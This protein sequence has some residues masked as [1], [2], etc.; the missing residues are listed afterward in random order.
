MNGARRRR[1]K[2]TIEKIL[3]ANLFVFACSGCNFECAINV[4]SS[5]AHF[6]VYFIY[7]QMKLI[8]SAMNDIQI[9]LTEDIFRKWF[10]RFK[11][12]KQF[13]CVPQNSLVLSIE[14]FWIHVCLMFKDD[15]QSETFTIK[16]HKNSVPKL[17]RRMDSISFRYFFKR[18]LF[19]GQFSIEFGCNGIGIQIRPSYLPD[20]A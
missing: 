18:W 7:S 14:W 9:H 4:F 17:K 19:H 5:S 8:L 15:M 6:S 1:R 12:L 2:K 10:Q 11:I 20:N 13:Q 3:S 16:M